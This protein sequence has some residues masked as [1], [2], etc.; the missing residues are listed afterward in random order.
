M[1]FPAHMRR[2]LAPL[3]PRIFQCGKIGDESLADG[4]AAGIDDIDFSFRIFFAKLA[5]GDVRGAE[6]A[7]ETGGKRDVNDILS[8]F[9]VCCKSRDESVD[10][11]RGGFRDLFSLNF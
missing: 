10:A 8:L 4:A 3:R 7:A 2:P 1:L 9:K 11:D 6:R 5:R